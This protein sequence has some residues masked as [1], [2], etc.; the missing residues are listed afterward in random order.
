TTGFIVDRISVRWVYPL[1]VF[2]WSVVGILTGYA[3]TFGMLLMCRL[4][5]GF[6]EAGNWPCGIRTTRTVMRP[7]ERSFGNALFG[8][9][10]AL[11]AVITPFVVLY[12]LR[13]EDPEE[14]FRNA[15]MSVVGGTYVAVAET[16]ANT[17]QFPFRVIGCF[18]LFWVLLWF[19]TIPGRRLKPIEG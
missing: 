5:L 1:M 11:G 15:V 17:W 18:G 13:W 9:G 7:E 12:L 2:G 4:A 8:S 19:V 14:P 10:T 3:T 16:P 6:F